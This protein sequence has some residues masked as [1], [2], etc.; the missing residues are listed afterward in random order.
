LNSLASAVGG[1]EYLPEE[2]LSRQ[3]PWDPEKICN[4]GAEVSKCL[5]YAQKTTGQP[6][7]CACGRICNDRNVFP[8]MIGARG[9]GVVAVICTYRQQIV[10]A[11]ARQEF[12]KASVDMF[13]PAGETLNVIPVSPLHIEIY[14]VGEYEAG[15]PLVQKLPGQRRR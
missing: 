6:L 2:T 11:K 14:E 12:G 5:P 8:G 15:I 7:P 9:C 3:G 1:L 10:F 13:E 4:S